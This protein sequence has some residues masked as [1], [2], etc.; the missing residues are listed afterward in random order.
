M[1][2]RDGTY[3]TRIEKS[4]QIDSEDGER[5]LNMNQVNMMFFVVKDYKNAHQSI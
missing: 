3:L 2:N 1:I 4:Y 5:K